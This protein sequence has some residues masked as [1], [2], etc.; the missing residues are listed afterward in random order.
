[1]CFQVERGLESSQAALWGH[2]GTLLSDEDIAG[3]GQMQSTITD[4][5]ESEKGRWDSPMEIQEPFLITCSKLIVFLFFSLD[6]LRGFFVS[7]WYITFRPSIFLL[8]DLLARISRFCCQFWSSS[9]ILTVFPCQKRVQNPTHPLPNVR[10]SGE[11]RWLF[12]PTSSAC[13]LSLPSFHECDGDRR[14]GD[15]LESPQGAG[16]AEWALGEV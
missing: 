5:C 9:L 14:T 15:L 7:A 3:S 13:A 11:P 10:S 6:F 2:E 1:M 8:L 16:G 4:C 12:Q